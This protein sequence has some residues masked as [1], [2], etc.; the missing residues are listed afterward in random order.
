MRFQEETMTRISRNVRFIPQ[1]L[2]E[3]LRYVLSVI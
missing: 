3:T 1:V 2:R